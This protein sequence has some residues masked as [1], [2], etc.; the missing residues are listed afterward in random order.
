MNPEPLTHDITHDPEGFPIFRLDIEPPESKENL[1]NPMD[2]DEFPRKPPFR[3]APPRPSSATASREELDRRLL[4]YLDR[5]P[6]ESERV[7]KMFTRVLDEVADLKQEFRD[8]MKGV[9]ARVSILEI[10]HSKFVEREATSLVQ[11]HLSERPGKYQ[12]QHLDRLG[13][14]T[15]AGGIKFK[16]EDIEH[17]TRKFAEQEARQKGAQEAMDRLQEDNERKAHEMDRLWK[18]A[19]IIGSAAVTLISGAVYFL[20]HILHL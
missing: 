17:L 14:L 8:E 5:A 16:P 1:E 13:E 12:E 19:A 3:V 2:D 4:N 20:T 10:G 15:P 11:R 6:E 9:K 7:Q 18:R